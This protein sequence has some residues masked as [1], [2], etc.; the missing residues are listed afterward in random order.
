M[1]A[2]A[3]AAMFEDSIRNGANAKDPRAGKFIQ[4]L[5]AEMGL[6]PQAMLGVL[7]AFQ[8]TTEDQI[9]AIKV[10]TLVVCGEADRDNG[11]P[12]ELVDLLPHGEL[13][14]V[15]GDHRAAAATP[16]LGEA[17]VGFLTR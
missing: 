2:G 4:A 7:A 8:E 6:N 11:S 10:P 15:P 17:V 9:R 16:E 13:V 14:I 3:R 1:A 5:M 12:H